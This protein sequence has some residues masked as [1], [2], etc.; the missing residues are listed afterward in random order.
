MIDVLAFWSSQLAQELTNFMGGPVQTAEGATI[1]GGVVAV[2]RKH[3]CL[4]CRRWGHPVHVNRPDGHVEVHRA[5]RVHLDE[6]H[7]TKAR[8]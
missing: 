5:C 8:G 6:D 2:Y 7:Y 3:K 1:L 4:H